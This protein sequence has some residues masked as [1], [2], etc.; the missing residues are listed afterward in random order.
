MKAIKEILIEARDLIEDPDH[1]TQGAFAK[2]SF[3]NPVA[4]ESE[5]AESWCA[6]GAILKA[7]GGGESYDRDP[8]SFLAGVMG[9]KCVP[10]FNDQHTHP[11]VIEAFDR[12]IDQLDK[13]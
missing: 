8:Y 5:Y 7:V 1:W 9:A 2:G 13:E 10:A 6:A 12:A 11:E 4:S 3:G